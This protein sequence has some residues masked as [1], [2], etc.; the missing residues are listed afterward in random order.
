MPSWNSP[1]IITHN[2][3]PYR[4]FLEPSVKVRNLSSTASAVNVLVT[5]QTSVFGIGLPRTPL[6]T[7]VIN[8]AASQE[9]ELLYQFSQALLNGDPRIGVHVTIEHPHDSNLLNSRASQLIFIVLTSQVGR[10][11]QVQFPVQNQSPAA[12]QLTL[13]VLPNELIASV[14][15]SVRNFAPFEQIQAT[16]SIQIPAALHGT[17][18]ARLE[19][20]VSIMGRGPDGRLIDGI[21]I[22]VEIDN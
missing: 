15:P 3:S 12:R 4:L 10:N 21:T 11:F 20:E 13:S 7:K 2:I 14:S 8:L 6:A 1:D 22:I 9:V 19:K 17:P 18:A 5:L 16:A